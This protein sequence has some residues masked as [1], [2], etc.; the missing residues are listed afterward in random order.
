MGAKVPFALRRE[1]EGRSRYR[2]IGEVYLHGFMHGEA[3]DTEVKER[4]GPVAIC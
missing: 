4:V 3:L 1:A 2:L